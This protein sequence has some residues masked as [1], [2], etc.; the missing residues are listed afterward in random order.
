VNTSKREAARQSA[1]A[2]RKA[3][4]AQRQRSAQEAAEREAKVRL[5]FTRPP[6][7]EALMVRKAL[8]AP[9]FSDPL[10]SLVA[11]DGPAQV[12]RPIQLDALLS[13]VADDAP[14]L[15]VDKTYIA[16]FYRASTLPWVRDLATWE[17]KGKGRDTLLRS[18]FEHLLARYKTPTFVWSAFFAHGADARLLTPIVGLVANGGSLHQAVKD[19]SLPVPLTRKMC[20]DLL[21]TPAGTGFIEAIRRVQVRELGGD[22]RLL[23]AWLGTGPGRALQ[24]PVHES[25]WQTVLAFFAKNPMLDRTQVGPLVDFISYRRG[26]EHDFSMKGRSGLA[27]LRGM[28]EWHAQMHNER[29]VR[30]HNPTMPELFKTSGLKPGRWDKSHRSPK[31]HHIHDLWY[32]EEIL[33]SSELFKEG[34]EMRHCV[35]SY[36]GRIT[37]GDTSIWRLH[38]EENEGAWKLLTIEVSNRSRQIVQA[39]GVCNRQPTGHELAILTA[40]ANMNLLTMSLGRW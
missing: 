15:L 22:P 4:A 36:G 25:F 10:F 24:A 1:E 3:L 40:W 35:A 34:R 20:H 11:P 27:L 9:G 39:R 17:P 23:R 30:R 29:V 7:D 6:T 2:R 33:S 32:I 31:G 5:A 38:H 8:A 37:S 28:H 13:R 14:K 26:Q 21:Q 12:A 18:L 19:G 16:A